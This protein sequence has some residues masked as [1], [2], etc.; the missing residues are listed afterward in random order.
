MYPLRMG[1]C[2]FLF[3][4]LN[5]GNV[6][7]LAAWER[8][9]PLFSSYC[10]SS[11]LLLANVH[12]RILTIKPSTHGHIIIMFPTCNNTHYR[13]SFEGCNRC[14]LC[15]LSHVFFWNLLIYYF[16]IILVKYL[17]SIKSI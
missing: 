11:S 16:F 4:D 8:P 15:V 2:S 5:Y 3:T 17:R 7:G 1:E 14:V 6:M 10:F 13:T 12:T 9:H